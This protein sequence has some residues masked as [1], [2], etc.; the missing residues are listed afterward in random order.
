MLLSGHTIASTLFVIAL[1]M[2]CGVAVAPTAHAHTD[3]AAVVGFQPL[4]PLPSVVPFGEVLGEHTS[5]DADQVASL[6][7]KIDAL[8]TLIAELTAKVETLKKQKSSGI[9]AIGVMKPDMQPPQ[10]S[11]DYCFALQHHLSQ[12]SKDADT[13]GEVTKLQSFLK[14]KGYYD[15]PT[16]TG[17]FGSATVQAVQK[18]Q[19][20]QGIVSSG[21]TESTGYGAV[22]P[23]T[24]TSFTQWC[25]KP[26]MTDTP[27]DIGMCT[28]ELHLCPDGTKVGRTGPDCA[29]VCPDDN[30]AD[31]S[32]A[33]TMDAKMCPDGTYVGRTGPDCAFVCPSATLND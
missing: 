8:R 30:A 6:E 10:A 18:W 13:D 3:T 11:K 23:K 16:V 17:Y 15:Y 2:V 32:I 9:Y 5:T 1:T 21:T 4:P 7:T 25:G 24:R 28:R 33:C 20:A 26:D 14:E 27:R 22:G 19:A 12:G 29:F 31:E